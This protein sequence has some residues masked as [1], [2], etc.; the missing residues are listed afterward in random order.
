MLLSES[1]QICHARSKSE[2]CKQGAAK[3]IFFFPFSGY[4]RLE[5]GSA[6][7]PACWIWQ[8]VFDFGHGQ[9]GK[10]VYHQPCLS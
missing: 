7:N 9:L 1:S 2:R 8:T 10:E 4:A 5:T 6:G 3:V